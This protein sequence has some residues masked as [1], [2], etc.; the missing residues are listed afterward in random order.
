MKIVAFGAVLGLLFAVKA[1]SVH[2]VEV[3]WEMTGTIHEN[4]GLEGVFVGDPFRVSVTFDSDAALITTQTGGRFEPGARYQYDTS[5]LTI[6][7]GLSELPEI[8][9]ES[10]P[11]N[12]L[13]LLWIRDNSGDLKDFGEPPVVDGMTM[14]IFRATPASVGVIFRG[15][16]IDIFDG[17]GLPIQ[18]DQ[19]L[20]QQDI[21][22]FV[23]SN[24][25]GKFAAGRIS[26]VKLLID[27]ADLLADLMSRVASINIQAGISNALDSKLQN[28]LDALD[29][30][31]QSDTPAAVQLL[32]AFI[33]S[34]EAQRGKALTDTQADQLVSD[35][36]A[37]INALN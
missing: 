16:I 2:A 24:N 4:T 10:S 19:R 18:P 13:Q 30:A 27:P 31:Q 20:L 8:V 32:S 37:I 6:V 17:P 33:N 12:S 7:A 14:G 29:R 22:N 21:S 5:V 25:D 15:S 28:V 36:Q 35:A 26:A 9:F 11:E 3:S 1:N 34:V 23:I